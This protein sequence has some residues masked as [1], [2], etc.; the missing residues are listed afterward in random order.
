MGRHVLGTALCACPPEEETRMQVE[1]PDLSG[2]V[3]GLGVKS[4]RLPD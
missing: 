4:P 3:W 1:D 2:V